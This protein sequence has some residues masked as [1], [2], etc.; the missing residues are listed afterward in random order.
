MAQSDRSRN[1]AVAARQSRWGAWGNHSRQVLYCS[2]EVV[3]SQEQQQQQRHSHLTFCVCSGGFFS[4]CSPV[5]NATSSQV[6]SS[7]YGMQRADLVV[8]SSRLRRS[9]RL[10]QQRS[11]I[12]GGVSPPRGDMPPVRITVSGCQVTRSRIREFPSA[13]R[14]NYGTDTSPSLPPSPFQQLTHV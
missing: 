13:T 4:F 8:E 5:A 14:Y 9:I 10:P 2:S 11:K 12:V 6:V 7:R 3:S 1:D